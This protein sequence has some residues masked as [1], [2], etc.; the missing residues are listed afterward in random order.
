MYNYS[1]LC[2][3]IRHCHGETGGIY[4]NA[5]CQYYIHFKEELQ[6]DIQARSNITLHR[7]L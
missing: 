4:K 7:F 1:A 2:N 3:T 6:A 5:G